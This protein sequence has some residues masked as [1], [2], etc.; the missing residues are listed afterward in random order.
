MSAPIRKWTEQEDRHVRDRVRSDGVAGVARELGRSEVSVRRRAS[1]LLSGGVDT[2][3]A[4]KM[5]KCAQFA[6]KHGCL[7]T[8]L[9]AA[10][11]GVCARTAVVW[12]ER[13]ALPSFVLPGSRDRRF[14][15]ADVRAFML[16]AGLGDR[17]AEAGLLA[18]RLAVTGLAPEVLAALRTALPEGWEAEDTGGLL[19]AVALPCLRV[20]LVGPGHP[21]DLRREAAGALR[22][23]FPWARLVAL[24]G[25][26]ERDAGAYTEAGY[27]LALPW[28]SLPWD[29]AEACLRGA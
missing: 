19:A 9:L 17:A 21:S 15:L 29:V 22:R 7:T 1:L 24:L 13:G 25:E 3:R 4:A 6:R 16:A 12:A 28:G 20:L 8:G 18:D 23:R 14:R 5:R 2:S 27:D 26:D 11:C 10:A